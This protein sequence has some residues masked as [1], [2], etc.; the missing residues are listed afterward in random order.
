M[1]QHM[2]Q[3]VA[4][5]P[6]TPQDNALFM[7]LE[8]YM[9]T[10]PEADS[11]SMDTHPSVSWLDLSIDHED[12][13]LSTEFWP[14]DWQD[15]VHTNKILETRNIN[16]HPFSWQLRC[17]NWILEIQSMTSLDKI[18]RLIE[19]IEKQAQG[20][21]LELVYDAYNRRLDRLAWREQFNI[22]RRMQYEKAKR[23]FAIVD[24][25][26][27]VMRNGKAKIIVFNSAKKSELEKAGYRA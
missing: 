14:E 10:N 1:V 2:L 16:E 22:L 19:S 9:E 11:T 7:S 15:Q 23:V 26:P 25:F 12:A 8:S 27:M 21:H 13:L 5:L 4:F 18:E 24:R 20:R 6:E 3:N 17:R